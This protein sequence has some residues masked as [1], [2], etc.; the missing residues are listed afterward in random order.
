MASRRVS[1]F[2]PRGEG[3]VGTPV[4]AS[5]PVGTAQVQTLEHQGQLSGVD[6]DVAST[7]G[8]LRGNGERASLKPLVQKQVAGSV[9][10]QEL[11]PIFPSF[12]ETYEM[13]AHGI[14]DEAS[15][16]RSQA[17]KTT[18]KISRLGRHEDPD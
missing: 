2:S 13:A 12:Q 9:P 4:P 6:L 7:R 3:L 10:D 15:C 11:D 5:M 8:W 18:P 17:I 1:E 14:E 16:R